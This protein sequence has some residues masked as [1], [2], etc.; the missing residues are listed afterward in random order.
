M[1][2]DSAVVLLSGGQD[3]ATCLFWARARYRRIHAFSVHYGQRHVAELE[4][5]AEVARL[6]GVHAHRTIELESIGGL[7]R[8]ALTQPHGVLAASG[9]YVDRSAPEGLPTSFLP[10]R[11]AL[12]LSLAASYAVDV[13][14]KD[15]VIGACLADASGYPDCRREFID[16]MEHAL[17][18]AMPSSCGPLRIRTP[19][20][21][22]SKAEVVR[23]AHELG[24]GCWSA[25]A[26]SVTCYLGHRPGCGTCPSCRVRAEGFA[27]AALSDP[28][29]A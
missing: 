21:D 17:T 7:A 1:P 3:S 23:L 4:A 25:L 27:L 28:A 18:L 16:V 19:L 12:L 22:L 29:V 10:G 14:A 2:C 11:N 5:A 26:A 20:I 13:G 9:G 15:I 6:A 24:E 8:S